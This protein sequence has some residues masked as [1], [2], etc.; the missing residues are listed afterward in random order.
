MDY[1]YLELQAKLL[2]DKIQKDEKIIVVKQTTKSGL[3][4]RINKI[5][6]KDKDK[7]AILRNK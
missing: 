3:P 7:T 2:Q 5:I 4:F 6:K 1:T